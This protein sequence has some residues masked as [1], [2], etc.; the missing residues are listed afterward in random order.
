[1]ATLYNKTALKKIKKDELIQMF[2]DQQAEKNDMELAT[3]QKKYVQNL[4]AETVHTIDK[5]DKEIEKLKEFKGDVINALQFD[6]DLDDEDYI[7]SIKD[8]EQHY[9]IK[10][11]IDGDG[12]LKQ[13]YKTEL[14]NS[15]KQQNRMVKE[16]TKLKENLLSKSEELSNIR[17]EKLEL[18]DIIF[19]H[20][21]K[22][23]IKYE[24]KFL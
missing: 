13:G 19:E 16:I 12:W 2:L 23:T 1:M 10:M 4:V 6:D 11:D 18:E 7:S 8:M 3:E 9:D 17:R 5:K 15:H 22:G 20:M 21:K 14:S 24:Q